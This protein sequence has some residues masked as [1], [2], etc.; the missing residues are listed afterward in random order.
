MKRKE[1]RLAII[2]AILVAAAFGWWRFSVTRLTAQQIFGTPEVRQTFTSANRVTAQ[3]LHLLEGDQFNQSG[4]SPILGYQ[5]GSP[6]PVS[7]ALARAFV[8]V[9]KKPSSYALRRTDI[10]KNCAI[11]YGV[12]LNFESKGRTVRAA[13]CFNC[14]ELAIFD[15][16]G[17]PVNQQGDFSPARKRFVRIIKSIFPEDSEIQAVEE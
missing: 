8:R 4:A 10:F 2:V 3:R 15:G 5:A 9:L 7:G 12:L 13:L 14:D 17:G 16:T 11:V 6:I 1:I